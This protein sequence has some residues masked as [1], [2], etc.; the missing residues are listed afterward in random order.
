[1]RFD[2][3]ARCAGKHLG[4][5]IHFGAERISSAHSG[6]G[7]EVRRQKAPALYPN[8]FLCYIL[9]CMKN[10]GSAMKFKNLSVRRKILLTNFMMIVIP[11]FIVLLVMAVILAG[12]LTGGGPGVMIA[13]A[14]KWAGETTNYQLQLMIDSI[15]EQ[16][17][18][19][20][21]AFRENSS[22]RELCRKLEQTGIHIA[23][24]DD[25]GVRYLSE[26]TSYEALERQ[27]DELGAS[28]APSFVRTQDGFACRAVT[29][30]AAGAYS[31]T[32]AAPGFAY[33]QGEYYAY[34]SIKAH[35]KVILVVVSAAAV[36]IILL[37]GVF[38]SRKLSR[39]ILDPV[40]KLGKAT[41]A[42]CKGDLD[43]PVG[44]GSEDELGQVCKGFDEM[45]I[46]LRESRRREERYRQQR[47]QLI[48]GISHDLSTPITS[49]QG[50]VSGILDGIAD[51]PEKRER[52][53]HTIYD[54]A[55]D[56]NRM[57]DGL[58]LLTKLDLDREP[59]H[60]ERTDLAQ[61]FKEK[62]P[63]WKEK[64]PDMELEVHMDGSR[65]MFVQI[66][67]FQFERVVA[68]LI[69]NSSK[70]RRGAHGK[71]NIYLVRNAGAAE[72]TF[73]DDGIGIAEN[74]EEKIFESFYR[75]D[76]AR[77]TEKGSGLGLAIARQIVEHMG[78]KIWA[79]AVQSG[80]LIIRIRLPEAGGEQ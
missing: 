75:A 14:E 18:E 61:Y 26:G 34:D 4:G 22:M 19:E 3:G 10:K 17:A 54:R 72:I 7:L 30:T 65:G 28:S 38:L 35:L 39:S 57:V 69:D 60:M 29:K 47:K 68:N 37:T 62:Y 48:A 45:R 41:E 13:A 79:Q 12:I 53:L 67:R 71:V 55:C 2:P 78:G 23:I 5:A 36:V 80:G 40:E 77:N 8:R 25:T 70:Y 64:I 31:I 15:S 6:A 9:S 42:L 66:D 20:E 44:Y 32:A 16:L 56:M 33:P 49:I 74:E 43:Q 46:R 50:Y 24:A 27:A 73:R 11:V 76:P 52:Y 21:D 59:F 51:T 1:M 58:F 63:G